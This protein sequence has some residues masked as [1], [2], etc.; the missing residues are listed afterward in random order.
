VRILEYDKIKTAVGYCVLSTKYQTY[1]NGQFPNSC[2][3]FIMVDYLITLI[4]YFTEIASV[5]KYQTRLAA[6]PKYYLPSMKTLLSAFSKSISV[7][8]F[9][10]IFLK[11]W[12]LFH[13]MHL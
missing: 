11:I 10:L 12:N 3:S 4:D 13:L 5:W 8:K 6:L 9:G 2:T 1:L 7:P